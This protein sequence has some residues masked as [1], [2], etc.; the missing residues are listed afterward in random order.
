M[1]NGYEVDWVAAI[2]FLVLF[3][4]CIVV[5]IGIAAG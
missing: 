1:S 3:V 4:F 5:M 2:M